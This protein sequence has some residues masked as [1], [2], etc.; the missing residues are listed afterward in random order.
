MTFKYVWLPWVLSM[1]FVFSQTAGV[2]HAAVH[3]FHAGEHEQHQEHQDHHEHEHHHGHE[4]EHEYH[5]AGSFHGVSCD[6]FDNLAKPVDHSAA[7][8]F[9]FER[10]VPDIPSAFALRSVYDRIYQAHFF[11]RAPPF[12]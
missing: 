10:P 5:H 4:D 1:L 7:I 2:V 6:V 12:A 8:S 3:P 11:G 9:A